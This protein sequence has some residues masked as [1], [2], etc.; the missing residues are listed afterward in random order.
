M[1]CS[2]SYCSMVGGC[3]KCLIRWKL[4]FIMFSRWLGECMLVM[5]V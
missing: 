2:S 3:L 4:L 5:K 1:L